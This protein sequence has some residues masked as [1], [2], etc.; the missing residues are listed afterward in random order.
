MGKIKEEILK[1]TVDNK[2]LVKSA[3]KN[4]SKDKRKSISEAMDRIAA[5]S[6]YWWSRVYTHT[7]G[8]A[9]GNH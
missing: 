1:F 2:D 7:C 8:M 9:F 5:R 3:L 6:D 4:F